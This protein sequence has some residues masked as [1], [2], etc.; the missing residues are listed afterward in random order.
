MKYT[1]KDIK[2]GMVYK[3]KTC[4][5]EGVCININGNKAY[6]KYQE[7]IEDSAWIID[8]IIYYL[9]NEFWIMLNNKPFYEVYN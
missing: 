2:I 8:D 3:H 9:N 5:E 4:G 1:D 7:N 6:F